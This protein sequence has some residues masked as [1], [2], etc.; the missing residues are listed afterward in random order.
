MIRAGREGLGMTEQR[1]ADAVGVSRSAVQQWESGATAPSRKKQQRVADVLGVTV[2]ELMSG[3]SPKYPASQ[4]T[5]RPAQQRVQD[6]ALTLQ[7]E[8]LRLFRELDDARQREAINYLRYLA[9]QKPVEHPGRSQ[10]HPLSAPL[11]KAA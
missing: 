11:G 10:H 5:D 1:F 4:A 6:Y 8:A 2:G 3:A 7:A 9:Q